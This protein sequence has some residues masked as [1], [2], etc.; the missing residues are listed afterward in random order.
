MSTPKVLDMFWTKTRKRWLGY[1][2]QTRVVLY[3]GMGKGG[4]CTLTEPDTREEKCRGSR[5]A[6]RPESL[7]SL[8]ELSETGPDNTA[9]CYNT[10][11]IYIYKGQVKLTYTNNCKCGTDFKYKG[12]FDLFFTF[13]T[14]LRNFA[15]PRAKHMFKQK[16]LAQTKI[17][18]KR[19]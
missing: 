12:K 1:R 3:H 7:C 11:H 10:H 16:F 13:G 9:Q 6:H 19:G 8:P 18:K 4:I 15:G 5:G 2:L 17:N 14:V